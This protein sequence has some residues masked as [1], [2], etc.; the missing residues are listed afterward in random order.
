MQHRSIR[1]TLHY[2]GPA[3]ERGR[4]WFT[5]TVHADGSRIMRAQSEIEEGEVLRDV[6]YSL[7][8]DWHPRDC[9]IRLT[10]MDRHVGSGWFRFEEREAEGEVFTAAEGRISQRVATPRRAR[11]FGSHAI[12]S[13][14]LMTAMF[15]PTGPR[16]QHFANLFMSS[17]AFNG[18][19]GPMLLP[20]EFGLELVGLEDVT[21][22]AGRFQCRRFRYVLGG[23]AVDGHPEYDNWVT[24]DGDHVIVKAFVG[25][26]KQ[27]LYELASLERSGLVK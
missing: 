10:V 9:S 3:G 11:A 12:V 20:I 2:T 1:G 19:T 14:G 27:Y 8:P 6:T 13:D 7:G 16:R 4:E 5:F 23:S 26:P 15:D 22:P 25:G 17:Y 24:D 21:V 18:A